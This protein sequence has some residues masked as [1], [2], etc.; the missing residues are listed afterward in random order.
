VSDRAIRVALNQPG[1]SLPSSSRPT[2]QQQ[3]SSSSSRREQ[4]DTYD[5]QVSAWQTRDI[6]PEIAMAYMLAFPH[7]IYTG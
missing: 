2:W 5:V 1:P 7:S 4:A 6:L 3:C